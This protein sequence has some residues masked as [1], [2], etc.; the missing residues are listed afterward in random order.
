MFKSIRNLF[1]AIVIPI[2]MA[3]AAPPISPPLK[4]FPS[5]IC[6]PLSNATGKEMRSPTK[7]LEVSELK[8][9][10]GS[11]SEFAISRII[12]FRLLRFKDAGF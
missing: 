4:K 3:A 8:C 11:V 5:E 9:R 1:A 12:P 7:R 6:L 2:A 10:L